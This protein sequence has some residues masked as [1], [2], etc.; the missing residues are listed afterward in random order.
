M[1]SAAPIVFNDI[2]PEHFAALETLA[3]SHGLSVVG[4]SGRTKKDGYDV[5]WDYTIANSNLT[6]VIHQSPF[7]VPESMIIDHFNEWVA[8]TKPQLVPAAPVEVV[9]E[10]VTN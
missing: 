5:E 2:T 4:N 1:H 8:D 10:A 6:I 3:Q 9:T 7:Y